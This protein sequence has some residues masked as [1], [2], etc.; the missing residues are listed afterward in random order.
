MF[1]E[2][3][4]DI[5]KFVLE[6]GFSIFLLPK[7]SNIN[8][9]SS[10]DVFPDEKDKIGIEK[11]RELREQFV[12]KQTKDLFIVVHDAD[13][14][15]IP[16]QNAFLKFLEEPSEHYHIVFLVQSLSMLLPTIL[17]RGDLYILREKN[18]LEAGI[19]AEENI[20]DYA[21]KL[22]ASSGKNLVSLAEAITKDKEYK[23]KDNSRIFT[24]KICDTAIEI[25]YKSYFK[26]KNPVFIKKISNL[27]ILS[28]NLKKNGNIK[29]HL[30]AD[31]C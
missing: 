7:K 12:T 26:T 1:F 30:I 20:K 22:L 10:F 5:D 15:N 2:S 3:I 24:L 9:N 13:K 16:A 27:L 14:M 4:A 29:L 25:A 8:I 11:I 17:S 31:L 19:M 6:S 21:K 23:R 28:E 18:T